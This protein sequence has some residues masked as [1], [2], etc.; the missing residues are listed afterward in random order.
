M[1]FLQS[2]FVTI[3]EAEKKKK[4]VGGRHAGA[5]GLSATQYSNKVRQDGFVLS[6]TQTFHTW[7]RLAITV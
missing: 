5:L 6:P 1:A 4:A 2:A 7:K 3:A